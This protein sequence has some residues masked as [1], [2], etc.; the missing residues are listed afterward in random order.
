MKVIQVERGWSGFIEFEPYIRMPEILGDVREKLRVE[1]YI[2]EIIFVH[3]FNNQYV[4][5]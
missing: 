3:S 4:G 2:K 5:N 1:R